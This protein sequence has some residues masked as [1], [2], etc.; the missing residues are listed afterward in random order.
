MEGGAEIGGGGGS[1]VAP[2]DAVMTVTVKTLDSQN[3]HFTVA[4]NVSHA[5]RDIMTENEIL[6][7]LLI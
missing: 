7:N 1:V 5:D 6:A 3:H 4:V 2:D